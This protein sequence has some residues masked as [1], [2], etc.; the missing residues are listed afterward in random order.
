MDSNKDLICE[1]AEMIQKQI[2]A[3]RKPKL[4][5][6]VELNPCAMY[7]HVRTFRFEPLAMLRLRVAIAMLKQ[8]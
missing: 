6:R 5:T 4:N 3:G 8:W 1:F 2:P 7:Y